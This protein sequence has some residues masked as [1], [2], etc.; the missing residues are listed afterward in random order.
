MKPLITFLLLITTLVGFAQTPFR[1]YKEGLHYAKETNKPIVLFFTGL[2]C[3][4]DTSIQGLFDK[5]NVNNELQNF[6]FIKLYVDDRTMLDKPYTI[7]YEGQKREIRTKGHEHAF[8]HLSKYQC[9]KTP[10][11]Y[12]INPEEVLVTDVE[13][14]RLNALNM[15]LLLKEAKAMY[16]T[17]KY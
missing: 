6:V 15:I 11:I 7:E 17:G 2:V 14:E 16:D 9:N 1:D 8:H 10:S 12:I 3:E 5:E 13:E 4:N